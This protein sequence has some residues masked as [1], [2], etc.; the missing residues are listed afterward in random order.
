MH[1]LQDSISAALLPLFLQYS[2][3]AHVSASQAL[4]GTTDKFATKSLLRAALF[5]LV[6]G[7]E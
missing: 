2:L 7:E 1:V 5:G 3:D 6:N 4:D